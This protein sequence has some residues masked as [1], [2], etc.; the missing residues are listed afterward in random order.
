MKT[1]SG[2]DETSTD[3][4]NN[5]YT[6]MIRVVI[7]GKPSTALVDSRA[8]YTVVDQTVLRQLQLVK[9]PVENEPRTM[10]NVNDRGN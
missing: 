4:S 6:N 8:C 5:D 3:E 10:C 1:K 9:A 7:M 2:G